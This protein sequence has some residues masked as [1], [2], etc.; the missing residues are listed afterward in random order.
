MISI[1]QDTQ[2]IIWFKNVYTKDRR[3]IIDLVPCSWVVEI[4]KKTFCFYP[5]KFQ[6]KMIKEWSKQSKEPN[7]KWEKT[8]VE[9]IKFACKYCFLQKFL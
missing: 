3:K 5:P 2:A 1:G 7:L 4:G 8:E 9:V 6:T